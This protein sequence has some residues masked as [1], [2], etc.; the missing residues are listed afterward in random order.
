MKEK[1]FIALEIIFEN[2][3]VFSAPLSSVE[4]LSI[5]GMSES[6][7]INRRNFVWRTKRADSVHMKIKNLQDVLPIT[8]YGLD[9]IKRILFS[10]D[11]AAINIKY[12]DDTDECVHV[13]WEDFMN[14]P[15]S[16]SWQKNLIHE[17]GV[18]EIIISNKDTE[19]IYNQ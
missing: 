15:N 3:E 5:E 19:V 12:T 9:F 4:Y 7:L 11:I 13:P 10:T 18:L 2:C 14:H 6:V 16:N 1:E 8:S 17:S